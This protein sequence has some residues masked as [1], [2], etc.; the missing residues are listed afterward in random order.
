MVFNMLQEDPGKVDYSQIGGLS[1][2]VRAT[3]G[4]HPGFGTRCSAF[5]LWVDCSLVGG[6]TKPVRATG[7]FAP[8]VI[9]LHQS[10]ELP[11]VELLAPGIQ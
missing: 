5:P 7:G 1:E 11:A 10:V 9:K 2:Q 3:V 8:Q 4:F 6:L